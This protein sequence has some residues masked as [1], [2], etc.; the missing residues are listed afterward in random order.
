M[1]YTPKCFDKAFDGD[2]KQRINLSDFACVVINEDMIAFNNTKKT[3]FIN[4]IIKNYIYEAD[5]SIHFALEKEKAILESA[6]KKLDKE[7]QNSAIE[8]LL[9]YKEKELIMKAN[10]YERGSSCAYRLW[11]DTVQYLTNT[12]EECREADYYKNKIGAYLK[13]VIEE[14][15]EKPY[16]ERERIYF[17]EKVEIIETAIKEKRRLTVIASDG[18]RYTV[19]P[20]GIVSDQK[21]MY[22]YLIGYSRAYESDEEMRP[23]SMR[24]SANN[25]FK[26]TKQNYHLNYAEKKELESLVKTRGVQFLLGQEEEIHVILTEAGI[27]QYNRQLHLRPPVA[28]IREGNEYIFHC[29]PLQ[30]EIYFMRLGKEAYVSK[31]LYLNERIKNRFREAYDLYSENKAE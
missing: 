5:A 12:S 16:I 9:K 24:I 11:E 17:A 8:A 6:L 7:A 28:E 14:Y 31:P 1:A 19:Y 18:N 13:A 20:Y 21:S 29:T 2:N 27:I 15:C 22:N 23:M 25:E 10:S 30:A 3:N 26:L 4:R